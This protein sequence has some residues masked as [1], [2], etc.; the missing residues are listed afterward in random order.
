MMNTNK[1]NPALEAVL[2]FILTWVAFPVTGL[3]ISQIHG[4][5]F[6]EAVSKNYLILVFAAASVFSAIQRYY[7]VKNSVQQ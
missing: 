6:A 3:L 7:K 1:K 2:Y 5:S 4:I